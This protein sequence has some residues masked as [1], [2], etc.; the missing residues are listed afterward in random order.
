MSRLFKP[1]TAE[2][3]RRAKAKAA[4]L[5]VRAAGLGHDR[6]AAIDLAHAAAGTGVTR[7]DVASAYDFVNKPLGGTD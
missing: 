2:Q 1:L 6:N 4:I 7:D 5:R 3:E